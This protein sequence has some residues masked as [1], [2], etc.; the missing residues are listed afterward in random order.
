MKKFFGSFCQARTILLCLLPLACLYGLL[1]ALTWPLAYTA[2]HIII[3]YHFGF[4]KRGLLGAL[5]GLIA[6][7]P[8]HYVTLAYTAFAVLALWLALLVAVAWR[9]I[10]TDIGVAGAV[11]LFFLSAGFASVVCD[12][13][14]GEH[15]GLLLALPCLLMPMRTPW[16]V[17]RAALLVA[18]VLMQ[19][20]NFLIVAP[21]VGFDV[22]ISPAWTTARRRYAASAATLL[23]AAL[24]TWY[25]GNART[26]CDLAGATAYYQHLAVDF[27]V[28]RIPI[29]TL[30]LD[31]NINFQFMLM[32]FRGDAAH[33][34]GIFL[35][36][37]VA[38]PSTLLNLAL[39][40]RI[41]RGRG[42]WLAG[43]VAAT[44]APLALLAFGADITRFVTLIQ[45][46]SLLVLLS[47]V[48]RIGLPTGGTLPATSSS[49]AILTLLAA[50]QLGTSLPLNDG[51]QIM[52]F[53][54]TPLVSRA[55]AIHQGKANFVVIPSY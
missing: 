37:I 6:P 53:P 30:C 46:T 16:L 28:Q 23:P 10:K 18:A 20:I 45:L 12:A 49:A 44:C 8:Y 22:L 54:F 5:L 32:L 51:S 17:L 1:S 4:G 50:Y 21:V 7:P 36:L 39:A 15:F 26:T 2:T 55:L 3:D 13:G 29:S 35:A 41:M 40:A 52:K 42:V 43:A 11:L 34:F 25:L 19:E 33:D 38:L 48:R 9:G 31:G 47:A 14:R 27:T 24:L